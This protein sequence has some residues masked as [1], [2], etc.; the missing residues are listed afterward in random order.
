MPRRV[1]ARVCTGKGYELVTRSKSVGLATFVGLTV[2]LIASSSASAQQQEVV[3]NLRITPG[4]GSL[5]LRWSATRS[6][7]LG[8]LIRYRALGPRD[9]SLEEPLRPLAS[10]WSA[11][12]ELPAQARRY[13]ITGLAAEPYEVKVRAVATAGSRGAV[14]GVGI[15]LPPEGS[16][17]PP[18][19]EPP[20]EEPPAEEKPEEPPAE[21]PPA[22]KHPAPALS[23]SPTGKDSNPCTEAAP[24]LTMAHAYEKASPGDLVQMLSGSY[25]SQTL[26][27]SSKA[28]SAHV[29]FAPAP[30]ASVT[31]TGTI[32]VF[33]SHVTIEGIAVQDVVTGNYDQTPGRPNPTDVSLLDLTGRN[34]EI[35]SAT[36]VT[37]EGGSWG[38]ASAC[39]GPYGGGNNSIRQTIPAVTPENITINNTIIHDVQSYDL[40]ECHI[41]G[42]AIFAGNHVTVSN[43]KFYGNSIYDVFMQANS[44][45]KPDNITI[46]GNWMAA[47]VDDSGANGRAVGASNG[48]A[49]GSEISSNLTLRANHFNGIVNINDDGSIANYTNTNVL[50]NFGA[51]AYSGYPCATELKG[52][53][54]SK[55]VWQND[56]CGSSDVDLLGAPLPYRNSSNGS[57]LDYTL[58]GVYVGWPTS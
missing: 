58:T 25:P 12:V 9:L 4:A 33:A 46:S 14:K 26:Q 16:K 11:P 49:L 18:A 39:G 57:S 47:A 2:A 8:F 23:I 30:S 56:K 38:P 20:A 22:E 35:D 5:G 17:E 34:F 21:E 13:T 3:R 37:V 32:Y 15:P 48:V 19:E 41:E 55:N 40:I 43:S 50:D 54:W 36:D 7:A 27:G 51:M 28:G 24:C 53:V 10:A 42:L 29:I 1:L 6:R 31:L 52:V 45:G 44:G